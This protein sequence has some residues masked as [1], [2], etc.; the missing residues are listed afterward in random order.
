MGE[1]I[2]L[3]IVVPVPTISIS[4]N[5]VTIAM[6]LGR[7]ILSNRFLLVDGYLQTLTSGIFELEIRDLGDDT[8]I[9]TITWRSPGFATTD[10]VDRYF[11]FPDSGFV[12][13]PSSLGV[14]AA[15]CVITIWCIIQP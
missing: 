1:P 13:G 15:N 10:M 6:P 11:T 3:P 7:V 5:V 4:P 2:F 9:G 14:G 12:I 8:L